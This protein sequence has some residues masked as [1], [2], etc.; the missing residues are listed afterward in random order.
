MKN[1]LAIAVLALAGQTVLAAP[2]NVAARA[3]PQCGALTDFCIRTRG[4][5]CDDYTPPQISCPN[6]PD[7]TC[8]LNCQCV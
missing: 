3:T 1:Y 6:A 7:F 5:F 2:N 4:C 8:N